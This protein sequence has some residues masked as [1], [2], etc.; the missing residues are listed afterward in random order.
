MKTTEAENAEL[1]AALDY[2]F[3]KLER[4]VTPPT[5]GM[6]W[7]L[8]AEMYPAVTPSTKRFVRELLAEA[9]ALLEGKV[10]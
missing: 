9:R 8:H 10:E 1:R 4:W 7:G 6:G 2:V 3:R 5:G